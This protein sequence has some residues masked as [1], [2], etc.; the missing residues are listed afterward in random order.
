MSC[1]Q[2][3]IGSLTVRSDGMWLQLIAIAIGVLIVFWI[4]FA[5]F[6]LVTRPDR[7]TL[8]ESA[9]LLADSLRLLRRL[10]TDRTIPVRTRLLVWLLIAYLA[11]PIDLI[12]DFIPVVGYADD[13]ILVTLVL[14]H[15][16]QRAG[17]EKLREHWPGSPE[18]LADF[19]RLLRI[20]P[21]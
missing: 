8:R 18:G 16:V 10:T 12:P 6:L 5:V 20:A 7:S 15:L 13:V 1:E 14:R 9:R 19:E 17:P 11:S 4:A 3:S 21:T 2:S